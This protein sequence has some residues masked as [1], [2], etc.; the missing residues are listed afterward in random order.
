VCAVVNLIM[1]AVEKREPALVRGAEKSIA[2]RRTAEL[3]SI[4]PLELGPAL[5]VV[6]IPLA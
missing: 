4:P 6:S 5:D 1:R 2:T 3:R